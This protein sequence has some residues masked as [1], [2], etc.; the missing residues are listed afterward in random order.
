M[1]ILLTLCYTHVE[2][3]QFSPKTTL[4]KLWRQKTV[5]QVELDSQIRKEML[6]HQKEVD[7]L[8]KVLM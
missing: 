3:Q 2:S 8:E 5:V 1:Y 7:N 4:E 6:T